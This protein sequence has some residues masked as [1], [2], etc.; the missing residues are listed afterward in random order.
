MLTKI[1]LFTGENCPN[2]TSAKEFLTENGLVLGKDYTI[3]N[4]T[5]EPSS[6]KLLI[7]KGIMTVPTIIFNNEEIITGFNKEKYEAIMAKM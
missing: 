5:T 6:R 1:L 2:C 7:S 4:V 3:L